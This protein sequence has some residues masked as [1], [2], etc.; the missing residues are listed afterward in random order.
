MLRLDGLILEQGS[1][2]LSAD[3]AVTSNVVTAI[4]GPSG[5]GKSTLLNAMAGFLAP[6]SGRVFWGQ[7]DL[8]ERPPGERPIAMLFQD[9]NLFPHLTVQQNVGLG[10]R[11][12]LRLSADERACVAQALASVG[13]ADM[14]TR[15]PADLSGGQ[16]SRAAL[17]R[18][19]VGQAPLVLLDEP[20]AA[21]GPG[22]RADMLDLVAQKLADRTVLM[23]SHSPSDAQRVAAQTLLIS[24]GVAHPPQ[25]TDALFADPPAAL[26]EYLGQ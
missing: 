24:D 11:P 5:C 25:A 2:R 15:K 1:F 17:A 7:D 21:L 4:V 26:R 13:L 23:V 3:F 19:L 8:T 16:Q 22:L 20:F 14:G 18:I 12:K 6:A 10:I 9:N